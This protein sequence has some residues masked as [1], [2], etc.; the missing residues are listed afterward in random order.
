MNDMANTQTETNVLSA[1]WNMFKSNVSAILLIATAIGSLFLYSYKLNV[2]AETVDKHSVE[3]ETAKKINQDI[4]LELGI[5]NSKLD[6]STED[7]KEIKT[8]VK[9]IQKEIK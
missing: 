7:L 4:L 5:M 6:S 8:D 1:L 2:L 3:I 9:E